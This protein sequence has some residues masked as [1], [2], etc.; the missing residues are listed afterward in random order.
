MDPYA[1]ANYEGQEGLIRAS[2]GSEGAY[3]ILLAGTA[4]LESFQCPAMCVSNRA[5]LAELALRRGDVHAA[6]CHLKAS[7]WRLPREADPAGAPILRAEARLA[8]AEAQLRR[9]HALACDGLEAAF[10]GGALLLVVELLELVAITCADLG[11]H[12]EAARLLG[13]AELQREVTGYARWAPGR[14]EL[15]PVIVDVQRALGQEQFGQAWSEGRAVELGEAVAYARRGRAKHSGAVA[16]WDSLT[17]TERR[18]VDLVAKHLTNA[19]IAQQLFISTAT[20]KSHLTRVFPK[21]GVPGRREL[22]ALVASQDPD[23]R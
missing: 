11:R 19:E 2:L 7:A 4:K 22:A 17:P 20:V 10:Q 14:D 9:A 8:R 12:A 15:A 1:M 3:E 18:V 6:R 13:T 5:V 16:G 23:R 21:L